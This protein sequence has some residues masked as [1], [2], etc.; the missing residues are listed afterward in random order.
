M[1]EVLNIYKKKLYLF[2]NERN[3]LVWLENY[4]FNILKNINEISQIKCIKNKIY[5]YIEDNKFFTKKIQNIKINHLRDN[6]FL[7]ENIINNIFKFDKNT[8]LIN[9]IYKVDD[10]LLNISIFSYNK[11]QFMKYKYYINNILSLFCLVKKIVGSSCLKNECNIN[12]FLTKLEKR[13]NFNNKQILNSENV[14]TGFCYGCS[15][16]N[17]IILYREE[18]FLKVLL[19]ELLHTFGIDK[20]LHTLNANFLNEI[21]SFNTNIINNLKLYESYVEV[22]CLIIYTCYIS[23]KMDN[24]H[25]KNIYNILYKYQLI[26][27]FFQTNKILKYYNFNINDIFYKGNRINYNEDTN[28]FCYYILKSYLL[29]DK[30]LLYNN[31]EIVIKS[32]YYK[33]VIK[34]ILNKYKNI[35]N[36]LN[37]KNEIIFKMINQNNNYIN[38]NLRLSVIDL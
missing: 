3:K 30:Y 20:D 34:K 38:N 24:I 12:I 23:Y 8:N 27:S 16:N 7:S 36:P 11:N 18:E 35:T 26:H 28:V 22:T 31:K 37:K 10:L 32:E 19:H 33:D 21:I 17:T 5:N 15:E 25:Y 14:N 6:M 4:V 1:N 2:E 9:Y 13:I 29:Y